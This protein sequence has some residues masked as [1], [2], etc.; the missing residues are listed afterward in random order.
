MGF[1]SNGYGALVP[2]VIT[3]PIAY[4][5]VILRRSFRGPRGAVHGVPPATGEGRSC[6]PPPFLCQVDRMTTDPPML[7]SDRV[8]SRRVDHI[9]G[10]TV[11]GCRNMTA[12]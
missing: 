2:E 7:V 4:H 10:P 11:R 9:I 12:G 1:Y 6:P 3:A 5:A 8:Q